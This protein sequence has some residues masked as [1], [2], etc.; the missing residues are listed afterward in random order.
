MNRTLIAIAAAAIAC[1]TAMPADAAKKAKPKPAP[2][3][4]AANVEALNVRAL[5]TELMVGA[6]AC[7][8]RE[9]YNAFVQARQP[10]LVPYAKT[11]Q[12]M[13]GKRTNAFVTRVANAASRNA[14]C[15]AI[16]ALFDEALESGSSL[17]AI[18]AK[19]VLAS[20]HG[21]KVCA[22][23]VAAKK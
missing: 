22:P 8:E 4:S 10:E 12:R 7:G 16:S 9:R 11:L 5:Q 19:D 14:D 3:T 18:A 6:L 15:A 23:K 13:H 20:R 2:C 1:S 17:S 21:Y